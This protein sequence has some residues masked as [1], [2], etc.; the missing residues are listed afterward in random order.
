M[1]PCFMHQGKSKPIIN[2]ESDNFQPTPIKTGEETMRFWVLGG[3]ILFYISIFLKYP[4]THFYCQELLTK[5]SPSKM[6]MVY[7]QNVGTISK[8]HPRIGASFTSISSS[9][10]KWPHMY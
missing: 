8:H 2:P 10:C 5:N 6:H 1:T 3:S 9:N 7:R 4:K